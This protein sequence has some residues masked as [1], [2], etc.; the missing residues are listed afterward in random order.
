MTDQEL[1]QQLRAWYATE[2]S[3]IEPAPADLRERLASIPATTPTTRRTLSRR[4]GFT[5]LAVAAVL[6][7]GGTLAAG[8]GLVRPTPVVTPPPNLAIVPP[9]A[10]PASTTPSP[11]ADLR[12]GASIAFVRIVKEKPVCP[13]Y[14]AN[15]VASRVWII[16]SDGSNAHQLFP[17]GATNQ[18]DLAWSP[19]GTRLLYADDGKL[20]LTDPSGRGPEPVDT[21]C[22]APCFGDSQ[23]TFSND[24]KSIVF[25][26]TS[27]DASGFGGPTAIATMD[28]AT[29]RVSVLSSTES[30]ASAGPGW[31]PDGKQI[32]F[33][34][35]GEKDGGG[36][37]PPRL[38]AVWVVDADGQNLR[39]LSP[40]TLAAQYPE[41]SPDG[42]RILFE[43]G[44]LTGL[45]QDIYTVRPDGSDVRRLTSDATSTAATWTADGRIM[46]AGGSSG[47]GGIGTPGWWTMNADG[48]NAA[49]LVPV[50]AIGV[51][52]ADLQG[53]QPTWQPT[54]GA[55]I[56]PPPWTAATAIAVG[57]PAPTPSPTPTPDLAPGFSWTG[58]PA[59]AQIG[60]LGDTATRL[61]DGRVLVAGGCT[62][63]AQLYDPTT[64]T[65]SPT[66]SL[67]PVRA[68]ATATLLRDGRVLFAGGYTCAPGSQDGMWASAE[69]YDP[70]T[71]TFGPTG[72]MAA[73]RSQHT[74]TLLAD[75]RVLIVG[76]IT[77]NQ[78]TA[79]GAII[80]AT[81]QLAETDSGLLATAEIYDPTTGIFS[82]TGSM[83]S[84]HRGHTATLLQDGRVLVV[85]N[86]GESTPSSRAAD[87]YD[88]ATGRFSKTGPMTTGRWL[89]TATLLQDGRI[90]ILGGRTPLDSVYASAEMYD[91]RSGTFRTAGSMGEA[92]QQQT[93]TLLADGRVF[94]AGGY[95]SDGQ[96]WRV[97]SSTEMYDPAT[98]NFSPTGSMGAP[99]D[100]HISTL[101]NDGRVLI[102]GGEDIGNNGG[103][104]VASA[105]LYQP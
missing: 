83:T 41:W 59:V 11:I 56:V 2:V 30:D 1:D 45:D 21:G 90:L 94:I 8:S 101:L 82:K 6:V 96:K 63:A 32:V 89:H 64:G 31:S 57:P 33:F 74:A 27:A 26:R 34:R 70:T 37:V 99:R 22:V 73:P 85:G 68:S 44:P 78:A 4:R 102:A 98:G 69:L 16:G 53:T 75:G 50:A 92:R 7:V 81:Y 61:A 84:A 13:R 60:G 80:L 58:S 17:E 100:G 18:G 51:A 88:P 36:P 52:A 43:S 91:P 49:V 20:Y 105:V 46:F 29:G 5:L 24:G 55:A 38:S 66:G 25:V 9:S 67:A 23:V 62:T 3:E 103:V 35:F 48:T 19:D 86:G 15:C 28:L 104:G 42:A 12:P 40:L 79:V 10:P 93:A 47:A 76:G 14:T 77:G 71:G 97:L 39:Q 54:G 95:W 72:S 65:F 87:I